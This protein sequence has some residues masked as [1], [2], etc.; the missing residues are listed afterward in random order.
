MKLKLNQDTA[1][2]PCSSA[3]GRPT[4]RR[5]SPIGGGYI[6]ELKETIDIKGDVDR[7]RSA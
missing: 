7:E 6:V 1:R 5:R 2:G 4:S 3:T